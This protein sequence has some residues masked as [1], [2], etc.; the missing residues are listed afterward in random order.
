MAKFDESKFKVVRFYGKPYVIRAEDELTPA[1]MGAEKMLVDY[2]RDPEDLREKAAEMRSRADLFD[3]MADHV[4]DYIEARCRDMHYSLQ[5][6][7]GF[8][9]DDVLSWE[10]SS[11]LTKVLVRQVV[12]SNLAKNGGSDS[13]GE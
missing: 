11:T 4:D 6:E 3:A 8:S 9:K 10:D 1:A 5:V 13:E 2:A 12:A 7:N